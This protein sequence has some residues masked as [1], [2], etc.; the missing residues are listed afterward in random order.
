MKKI[1][2]V[3]L[4][5]VILFSVCIAAVRGVA[6]QSEKYPV[7]VLPGYSSSTLVTTDENGSDRQVWML[8]L[9]GV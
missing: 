8:D 1:I 2:S 7:V 6:E 5:L 9:G 4:T 3:F